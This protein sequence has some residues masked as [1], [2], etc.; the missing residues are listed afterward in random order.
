MLLQIRNVIVETKKLNR[1]LRNL[2]ER[3]ACKDGRNERKNKKIR[4]PGQEGPLIERDKEKVV[5]SLWET[6][7]HCLIKMNIHTLYK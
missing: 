6:I 4:K 5:Q 3:R 2:P 1:K 7:L